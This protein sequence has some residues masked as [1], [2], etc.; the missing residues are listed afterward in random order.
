VLRERHVH[1][2]GIHLFRLGDVEQVFEHAA[3]AFGCGIGARELEAIAAVVDADA[4]L[5]LDLAQVLVELPAHAREPARIGR[6][7]HDGQRRLGL[8]VIRQRI[9]VSHLKRGDPSSCCASAP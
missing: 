7:Q 3:A 6:R 1:A 5:T 8:L 2:L 4:E 9:S